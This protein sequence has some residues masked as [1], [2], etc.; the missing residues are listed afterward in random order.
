MIKIVL[1]ISLIVS[2]ISLY[3]QPLQI[4]SYNVE[5]FF[6]PDRDTI[7]IP[8]D[9]DTTIITKNDSDWTPTGNH[10]W[11]FTRY[12]N[13]AENIARV[14]T[15]IGQWN[16]VD[17]I[18]LCEVEN[19]KCLRKLCYLMRRE[20]YDYVHYESPDTRGID[21]ALLYKKERI[22]T[23][24]TQA[25]KVHIDDPTR[26]IL[27]VCAQV[28]KQD[29]LHL[30]VCHLPSQLGGKAESE[31]KRIAAKKVLQNAV[32]S[33][34]INQP[35]A[36]IVVMGDMN[37]EPTQDL[38]GLKNKMISFQQNGKG[39]HKW[40][41]KW[42]CLDQFYISESIDSVATISIYDT[43]WIMETDDKYLGLKPKRTF[44]GFRY[45]NGYSDHLPIVMHI[46]NNR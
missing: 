32:D 23:I 27:Y 21:V 43:E 3:A 33:I 10:R 31:Y 42:S 16:G 34:V 40:Q 35:H 19:A 6:Y 1:I 13:K 46:K 44:I 38:N 20:Q 9:N 2:S 36:K 41:G 28:D 25:I 30:F 39:T 4:V 14:I 5:N 24:R 18:G 37:N 29:T 17:I 7:K 15:N 11:S 12:N 22:D 26:D 8:T 45:N